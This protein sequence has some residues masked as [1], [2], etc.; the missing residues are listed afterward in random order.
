MYEEFEKSFTCTVRQITALCS[1][2]VT[3]SKRT[4]NYLYWTAHCDHRAM[5]KI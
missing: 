4:I 3:V 2:T 1:M 5:E